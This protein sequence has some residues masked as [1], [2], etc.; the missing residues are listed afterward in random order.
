MQD[1]LITII[2]NR[3]EEAE[4]ELAGLLPEEVRNE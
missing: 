4:V 3:M 1:M 2:K